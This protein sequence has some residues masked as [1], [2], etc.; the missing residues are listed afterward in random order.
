MNDAAD[1]GLVV[2]IPRGLVNA[3]E[4]VYKT[5]RIVSRAFARTSDSDTIVPLLY[6]LAMM[7]GGSQVL[8]KRAQTG[9]IS[10]HAGSGSR[11]CF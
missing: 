11:T 7:G 5:A 4:E 1:S 8:C 9:D 6:T 10:A 2:K 3:S